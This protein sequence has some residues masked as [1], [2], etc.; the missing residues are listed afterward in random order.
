MAVTIRLARHG[1]IKQPYY[2]IVVQ[3]HHRAN[4]GRFI[5]HIGFV[6]TLKDPAV[7]EFKEDRVRYWVD[8]GATTSDTMAQY[9]EKTIP[10]FLSELEEGRLQKVRS[11]RAK[12]KAANGGKITGTKSEA[13]AKRK[14]RAGRVKPEPAVKQEAAPEP[15][16]APAAE[17]TPEESAE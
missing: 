16:A 15:E 8:N 12:R 3:E 2:R 5:E 1:R 17:A 14:A 6:D 10:G 9:I 11:R 13:K 4:C 7:V